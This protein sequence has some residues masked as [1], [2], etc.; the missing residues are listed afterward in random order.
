MWAAAFWMILMPKWSFILQSKMRPAFN[1]RLKSIV[2]QQ[3][4]WPLTPARKLIYIIK[5]RETALKKNANAF[6]LSCEENKNIYLFAPGYALQGV[7]PV[8][9]YTLCKV[10]WENKTHWQ[11]MHIPSGLLD[12]DPPQLFSAVEKVRQTYKEN[13][14]QCTL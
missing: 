9:A 14:Q 1:T 12:Q 2:M 10:M 8:N 13:Q 5:R 7:I 11:R 3:E 4:S 6:F